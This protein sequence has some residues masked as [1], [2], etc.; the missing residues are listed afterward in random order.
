[1]G[2][3]NTCTLKDNALCESIEYLHMREHT[4]QHMIMYVKQPQMLDL[5]ATPFALQTEDTKSSNPTVRE[6]KMEDNTRS[7]Q[8]KDI[9]AE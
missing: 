5:T 6:A 7:D 3:S 4:C 2:H 9:N 1:M 8:V